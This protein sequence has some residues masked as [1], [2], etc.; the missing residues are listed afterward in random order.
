MKIKKALE[1]Q[2]KE[3][4][5]VI[6]FYADKES[7]DDFATTINCSILESDCDDTHGG[8]RARE[9]LAKR[10]KANNGTTKGEHNENIT[11]G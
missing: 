9:Y 5:S 1:Q 8:K 4:E 11:N 7:W 10:N 3:A 2:L 6:G